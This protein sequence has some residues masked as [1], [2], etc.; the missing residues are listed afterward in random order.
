MADGARCGRGSS[1][2]T[3]RMTRRPQ[4]VGLL[5]FA[6]HSVN[7]ANSPDGRAGGRPITVYQTAI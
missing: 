5:A 6:S 1:G 2:G 3:E 4:R 7:K